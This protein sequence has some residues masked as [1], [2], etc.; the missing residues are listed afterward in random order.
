[1]V[2]TQEKLVCVMILSMC[3]FFASDFYLPLYMYQH[4]QYTI[5]VTVC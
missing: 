1:M 4:I 5:Q 2:G 3:A